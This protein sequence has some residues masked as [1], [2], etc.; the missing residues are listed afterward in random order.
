MKE[1]NELLR[2]F[3]LSSYRDSDYFLLSEYEELE[4]IINNIRSLVVLA[5]VLERIS[6]ARPGAAAPLSLEQ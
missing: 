6:A 1:K 2:Y 5:H 3:I 4:S